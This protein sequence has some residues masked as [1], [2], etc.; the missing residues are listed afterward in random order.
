MTRRNGPTGERR[1]GGSRA[2]GE[3]RVGKAAGRRAAAQPI[4]PKAFPST[5]SE[6][7]TPGGSEA[8][9]E[10]ETGGRP[11]E[12]GEAGRISYRI[13]RDG[14]PM[15]PGDPGRAEAEERPGTRSDR[16]S[17]AA[18]GRELRSGGA[19]GA[20]PRQG[21]A[22][23]ARP[24]SPPHR[25]RTGGRGYPAQTPGGQIVVMIP[26]EMRSRIYKLQRP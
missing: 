23:A 16:G 1:R 11:S 25:E 13:R 21:R 9:R 24:S 7:I 20:E 18:A 12:I 5:G 4:Q 22:G 14:Q 17:V 3:A 10:R 19:A 6:P 2:T 26:G 8:E 15:R